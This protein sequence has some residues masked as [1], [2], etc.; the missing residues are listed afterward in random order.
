MQYDFTAIEAK[1]QAAW[2]KANLFR[3][4]RRH[5]KILPSGNVRLSFGWSSC[6][7]LTELH[8]WWCGL[9]LQT[10][11]GLWYNASFW[12][13]AFGLPAEEAAIKHKLHPRD[14]TLNNIKT[15]RTTLQKMASVMIGNARWLPACLI[16]TNGPNGFSCYCINKGWPI[17]PKHLL[18]GVPFARRVWLMNRWKMEPA[19]AVI[20]Q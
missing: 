11:A 20:P 6:R 5:V 4:P 16:I 13:D 7:T 15:S 3:T 17:V 14:W 18:I 10:D 12:V 8:D 1:W 19:G 9:S 2:A